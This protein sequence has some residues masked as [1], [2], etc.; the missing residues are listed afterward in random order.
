MTELILALDPSS[1]RTGYAVGWREG[2]AVEFKHAGLLKP[3]QSERPMIRIRKMVDELFTLLAEW[4]PRHVMVEVTSG[5]VNVGRHLGGGAGLGVYGMAAG[6]VWCACYLN[7]DIGELHPV[8]E[9]DWTRQ[10]HVKSKQDRKWR[11]E[12]LYPA[13]AGMKDP[14]LDMADAICL[15][16]YCAGRLH[17]KEIM[18]RSLIQ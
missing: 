9:N 5:K 14:G 17:R 1:T 10:A 8:L 16:D 7:P 12:R 3:R 6:A 13:Y 4:E 15:A 11:A 18:E 2:R